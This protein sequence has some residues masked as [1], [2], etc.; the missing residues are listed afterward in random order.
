MTAKGATPHSRGNEM[1]WFTLLSALIIYSILI[2]VPLYSQVSDDHN[3][4]ETAFNELCGQA[5][6]AETLSVEELTE[7]IA[8]CDSLEDKIIHSTHPKKKVL[9]FRL[10]KC[11]NFLNFIIQTKQLEPEK[12]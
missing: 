10:K 4:L 2:S 12:Q 9:L 6:N 5:E 7:M 11:R 8:Q 1:K 3:N